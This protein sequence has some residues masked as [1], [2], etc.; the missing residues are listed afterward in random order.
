VERGN[1][2]QGAGKKNFYNFL[3][4]GTSGQSLNTGTEIRGDE[5]GRKKRDFSK[6]EAEN[7]GNEHN[8]KRKAWAS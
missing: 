6:E 8:R 2:R 4:R 1:E 5:G 3:A 7:E